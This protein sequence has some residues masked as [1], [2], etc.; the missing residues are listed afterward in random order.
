M[1]KANVV[2]FADIARSLTRLAPVSGGRVM[3]AVSELT[4]RPDFLKIMRA[5]RRAGMSTV[6]LVTNGRMFCY[7]EFT[8][9]AV[10]AGMTHAL[11]SI[12]GPT[13]RTHHAITNTGEFRADGGRDYRTSKVPAGHSDDQLG[14]YE[15]KLSVF[16]P[17]CR[18]VGWL[19]QN[20]NLSFV[21]IIGAAAK[22]QKALVPRITDVLPHLKQ[23]VDLGVGL[24][25]NVGIGGLPYC[26]LKGY[27]HHF[28]VDDLT[29]IENSDQDSDNITERSPYAKAEACTRCAYNVACLGMQ[30]EYLRQYGEGEPLLSR[31]SS[32]ATP[33]I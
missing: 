15:E 14:N 7:P 9:R 1:K 32:G 18:N 19:V 22:Y 25:L 4:V 12:Y 2:P 13:P 21:Q 6:A 10:R 29:Y 16:A 24:G 26:V 8:A 17:A 11:V 30:D 5:S 3:Y 28:G 33:R 23:A 31:A 27:E 20:V